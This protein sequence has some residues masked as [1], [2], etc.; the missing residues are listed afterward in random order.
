VPCEVETISGPGRIGIVFLEI[1]FS[2]MYNGPASLNKIDMFM[3][4]GA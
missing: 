1:S 4:I 3:Q 2:A